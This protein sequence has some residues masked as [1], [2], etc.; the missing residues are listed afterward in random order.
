[1]TNTPIRLL[2]FAGSLRQQSHNRNLLRAA[3]TVLPEG[4]ALQ[5][6]DLIDI[7]L[8]NQDVEAEG[9]PASVMAFRQAMKAADALLIATPEY[10]WS[11]PGV[12]K[13]ALDWMSRKGPDAQAPLDG[14]TVA[15]MGAGGG[16]GTMRAQMHLR[17]IL[18]HNRLYVLPHPQ[19]MVAKAWTQF[20]AEGN[21]T[22]E[23]TRDRLGS[24]LLELRDFTLKLRTQ[25][26]VAHV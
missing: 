25:P 7:P 23:A 26:E 24:L 4:I 5:I 19:M 16:Y 8:F 3:E 17:E 9:T 20:D 12:L 10:N 6:F 13:N 18:A 1:M 2:G 11:I 15:I 22:D 14:K 21:L